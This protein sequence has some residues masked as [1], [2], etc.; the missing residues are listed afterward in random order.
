MDRD[1]NA[2]WRLLTPTPTCVHHEYRTQLVPPLPLSFDRANELRVPASTAPLF[3]CPVEILE[4]ILQHTEPF[5]LTS[6]ALASRDCRQLARSR[7][8]A[9]VQLDYSDRSFSLLR[10]LAQEIGE[11]TKNAGPTSL[12]SL[13]ACIRRITV[14]RNLQC[15]SHRHNIKGLRLATAERLADCSQ[16]YFGVY[17]ALIED[18]LAHPSA[19]PHLESLDWEDR[20]QLPKHLFNYFVW[21]PIKHL[22]LIRVSMSEDFEIELPEP[23][24]A[25]GWPLRTLHLDILQ[26]LLRNGRTTGTSRL[27]SSILR[28]CAPTLQSLRWESADRY[29]DDPHR[30]ESADRYK[31]DPQS[32]TS[33][34]LELPR[35]LCLR[36]LW[37]ERVISLDSSI[38]DTLVHDGLYALKI[39][40][41]RSPSQDLIF[42]NRG[43]VRSLQIFVWSSSGISATQSLHFLQA[44]TQLSKLCL[45]YP[46]PG[47]L[48][49]E[50]LLPILSKSF[51]DL[52]S[53]SLV[54]DS[55]TIPQTIPPSALKIIGSLN[56]LKQLRL[57]A[58][59]QLG[60]YPNWLIDHDMMRKCLC[61]L[62]SLEKLA[63]S[64]DTYM[65]IN[66]QDRFDCYYVDRDPQSIDSDYICEPD[67]L[68]DE[69]AIWERMHLDFTLSEGD[70]YVRAMSRLE[71][72][73]FGQIP[74]RV[75][76][77]DGEIG[78]H[79]VALSE[80]DGCHT[81]LKDMFEWKTEEE[82]VCALQFALGIPFITALI[83]G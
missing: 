36:Y 76:F 19:L 56:S 41:D 52:T 6:F 33:D 75:D 50:Q 30:Y 16:M 39:G 82:V 51:L 21:S 4:V 53:L 72:V 7:Q 5:S 10:A 26:P 49:E 80:R 18:V 8:L 64:R 3:R 44:N 71:W 48:L 34:S 45:S 60:W 42:Q 32:F 62:T 68:Q 27:S 29:H 37:L 15:I 47:V 22:K 1:I 20:I 38:L 9:S 35:F 31:D 73:Y 40:W 46:C 55:E 77:M 58:G 70:R 25:R 57:S 43:S 83:S 2:V 66:D 79:V 23:L 28:L 12:P 81:V 59:Q 24:A 74:M 11:R 63:F 67:G 14:A 61:T 69:E 78:R 13:G 17:L 54:W 65:G